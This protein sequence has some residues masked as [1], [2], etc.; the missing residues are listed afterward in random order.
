M[1]IS[2]STT[3]VCGRPIANLQQRGT[4]IT[5]C[6]SCNRN[7]YRHIARVKPQEGQAAAKGWTKLAGSM[8]LNGHGDLFKRVV[9]PLVQNAM[10]ARLRLV[11]K[12]NAA[13][14]QQDPD[15]D[16]VFCLVYQPWVDA[17][18]DPLWE[19]PDLT[20]Q[21]A[22]RILKIRRDEKEEADTNN[23]RRE[24][25]NDGNNGNENGNNG[26]N[27]NDGGGGSVSQGHTRQKQQQQPQQRRAS[28]IASV[29]PLDNMP[30][31]SIKWNTI[32][33]GTDSA[34][35]R[36]RNRPAVAHLL[37]ERPAHSTSTESLV[38]AR[39]DAWAAAALKTTQQAQGE[40][41]AHH[42]H[43]V[44]PSSPPA[45]QSTVVSSRLFN[46][47]VLAEESASCVGLFAPA[48]RRRH[49]QQQQ[50][51]QPGSRDDGLQQPS[52]HE[53]ALAIAALTVSDFKRELDVILNQLVDLAIRLR[54]LD[55]PADDGEDAVDR[56]ARSIVRKEVQTERKRLLQLIRFTLGLR[57]GRSG[58][59]STCAFWWFEL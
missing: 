31:S 28:S 1:C 11:I 47:T 59:D 19:P 21:T 26:N 38:A 3:M 37:P 30:F 50:Q 42:A 15:M 51:K 7:M 10:G 54:E 27:C 9:W 13:V 29:D 34:P 53:V 23:R 55:M 12:A 57:A 22:E 49:G 2:N 44:A 14:R 41:D 58:L 17:W 36:D 18:L 35:Q 45:P 20:Q 48:D 43:V 25:D 56:I 24:M 5:F 33:W 16:G 8:H 40:P 6:G 4:R 52:D 32:S 39:L 46:V